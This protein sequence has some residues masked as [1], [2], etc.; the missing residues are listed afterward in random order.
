LD[1]CFSSGYEGL[2]LYEELYNS[3]ESP[4]NFA[5]S[6]IRLRNAPYY[7]V[8]ALVE[9]LP[10]RSPE[11]WYVQMTPAQYENI[12]YYNERP[13]FLQGKGTNK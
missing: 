11:C 9:N 5:F 8:E 13:D 4:L 1:K 6:E 10:T 2:V 7:I 12:F 3:K